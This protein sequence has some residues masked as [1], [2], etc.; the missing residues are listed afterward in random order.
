MS[1]KEYEDSQLQAVCFYI[2][3]IHPFVQNTQ[4]ICFSQGVARN[5]PRRM[6]MRG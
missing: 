5:G 2:M 4:G 1:A 6:K 3:K